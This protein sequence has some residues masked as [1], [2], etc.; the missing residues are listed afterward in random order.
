MPRAASRLVPE[1]YGRRIRAAALMLLWR[2]E[3]RQSGENR[4][5]NGPQNRASHRLTPASHRVT[6]SES[7]RS[8]RSS[9]G[10]HPVRHPLILVDSERPVRDSCLTYRVRCACRPGIPLRRGQRR[11][12][13]RRA[14]QITRSVAPGRREPLP[15]ERHALR[16]RRIPAARP[17]GDNLNP[18]DTC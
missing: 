1:R 2:T 11:W 14:A 16:G 8:R 7:S 15:A 9:A 13:R 10:R 17:A 3:P 18:A 4:P 5:R 6:P 12:R